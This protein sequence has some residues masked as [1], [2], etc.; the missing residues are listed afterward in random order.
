[1]ISIQ[2]TRNGTLVLSLFVG[3]WQLA[4]MSGSSLG[5]HLWLAYWDKSRDDSIILASLDII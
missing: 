1:M 5:T 2:P 4:Y 3:D